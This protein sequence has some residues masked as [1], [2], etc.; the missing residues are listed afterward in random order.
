LNDWVKHIEKFRIPL[1]LVEE[2][3]QE[4]ENLRS[5]RELSKARKQSKDQFNLEK[6]FAYALNDI[7]C[8]KEKKKFK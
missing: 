4:Y 2:F 5:Q 1:P 6:N 7:Q 8:R 3:R